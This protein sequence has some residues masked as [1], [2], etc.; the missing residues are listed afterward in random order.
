VTIALF[1]LLGVA[2]AAVADYL[3]RRFD[4][5]YADDE[6]EEGSAAMR[7][8]WQARPWSEHLRHTLLVPLPPVTAVAGARFE[9]VDAVAVSL[10]VAALLICTATDL[11]RYRVPN[12][13][14][15]P[16]I[17]LALL[18]ALVLGPETADAV[19]AVAAAVLA[20]GIFLVMALVSRG[21]IG[22]GDVKLA[23]LIGA[24]LGLQSAYAALF[25]GVLSAG[26]VILL[27]LLTRLV[28]RRQAVPY[29]PFLALAGV[30]LL[31]TRGPVFAA[32]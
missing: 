15:Y 25:L 24:T 4:R 6:Q 2:L 27:L 29:A 3:V 14:T 31:L 10:L 23:T 13:V 32:L 17:A 11:L 9:P 12:A 1:F 7:L 30:V 18:A 8:P 16:G 20:G 26:A 28:N 22:L 21:G 19:D 5:G